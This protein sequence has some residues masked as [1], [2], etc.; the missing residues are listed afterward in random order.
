MIDSA[1]DVMIG[2][3]QPIREVFDMVD[4]VASSDA[5]ILIYGESGVGKELVAQAIHRKSPRC[6]APFVVIDCTALQETLLESELFGHE[7][8]AYTSATNLKYGLFEVAHSGV[9]LL[10][11]IGE[12]CPTIQSKLLRVLETGTFR[13][14]GGTRD[15]HVDVRVLAATNRNLDQLVAEGTFR[16]DLFYRLNVVS[17]Q[18]P[19]LRSRPQDIPRLVCHFVAHA[20]EQ[21]VQGVSDKAMALLMRYGWPGNVREL[22]NVIERA[23]LLC[24]GNRIL[25]EDLP[26]DL[27]NGYEIQV[28][29]NGFY[30]LREAEG[31]HIAKIL[32]Y[33]DGH[34]AKAAEVLGISERQLYRKLHQHN[35]S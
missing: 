26:V 18:V 2:K 11:E 21:E 9:V 10:D 15:I 4:R 27:R 30:S 13:R 1:T 35:L 16:E 33:V 7:Q 17:I 3:S 12:L 22:R 20:A 32:S 24:Q 28:H 31:N 6:R 23:A 14:V 25:P 8:G 34:R 29:T 5:N 19:P